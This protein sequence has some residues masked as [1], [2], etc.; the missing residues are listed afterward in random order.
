MVSVWT[1]LVK[2][3]YY[4]IVPHVRKTSC[5]TQGNKTLLFT[6][7]ETRFSVCWKLHR[8]LKM[9]SYCRRK[10]WVS[11]NA[12]II[13]ELIAVKQ[14]LLSVV[15]HFIPRIFQ[16]WRRKKTCLSSKLR[17]WYHCVLRLFNAIISCILLLQCSRCWKVCFK[18]SNLRFLR[19]SPSKSFAVFAAS[20]VVPSS[21]CWAVGVWVVGVS[22]CGQ[23]VLSVGL[24]ETLSPQHFL[25]CKMSG[26]FW[27]SV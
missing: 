9:N 19:I 8:H 1:G 2:L 13:L 12:W 18:C 17:Y 27:P 25:H 11:F 5:C 24:E 4:G 21:S 3:K 14:H 22:R 23:L 15:L 7:A 20:L 26:Y 10:A 16:I 6:L